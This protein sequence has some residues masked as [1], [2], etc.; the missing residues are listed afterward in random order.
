VGGKTES[1][2]AR[3][4]DIE[5]VTGTAIVARSAGGTGDVDSPA[6]AGAGTPKCLEQAT[7]AARVSAIADAGPRARKLIP[8]PPA[9]P[10]PDTRRTRCV[11][12]PGAR[13]TRA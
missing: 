7:L 4:R 13:T 11:D 8:G 3:S 6:S 5:I 9:R 12:V 1:V 2:C 10:A